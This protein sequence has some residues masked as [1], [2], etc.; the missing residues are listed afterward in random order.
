[1]KSIFVDVDTQ[2]DFIMPDGKL[3]VKD[4]EKLLPNF[5]RL[6]DMAKTNKIP[7]LASVDAHDK[8]DPEFANFPP[9]CVKGR[10][11]WEKVAETSHPQAEH[12]ENKKGSNGIP[13]VPQIVVEKTIFSMFGNPNTDEILKKLNPTKAFVYGVATDYCVK[14]AAMGLVERGYETY[15]IEDAVAGVSHETSEKAV[16][17]MK[18]AGVKF[19]KV[20]DVEKIISG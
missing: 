14:A 8:D 17:D 2:Y 15:V 20:D 11:G 1:M 6:M 13:N 10:R 9:H 5:K 7:I 16:E 12:V 19:I 3:Y 4:A 18:A